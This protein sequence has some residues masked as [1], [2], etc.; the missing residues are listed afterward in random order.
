VETPYPQNQ[1]TLT[2]HKGLNPMSS[3]ITEEKTKEMLT[4]ILI[5]MM[6]NKRELFYEIVLEALEDIG[7]ANA[8]TEG[9]NGE[10]VP[11]EEVFVI[12]RN[13]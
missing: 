8:I 10:F 3:I 11:E 4:E 6:Q 13:L 12:L 1:Q 7:L 9:L 2:I 5:E